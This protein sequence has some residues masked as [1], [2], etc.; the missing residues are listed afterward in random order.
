MRIT[1]LSSGEKR[2]PSMSI[3]LSVI[4]TRPVPSAFIFH[5]CPSRRKAIF[6]PSSIH[7]ASVSLLPSWVRAV[8]FAI[9]LPAFSGCTKSIVWLLFSLTL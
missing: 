1:L 8:A 3:L 6:L 2:N 7:A 4:F 5:S 9:V